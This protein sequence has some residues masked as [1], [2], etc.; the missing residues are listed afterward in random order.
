VA[1]SFRFQWQS[2]LRFSH[3]L[4]G[5]PEALAPL[6]SRILLSHSFCTASSLTQDARCADYCRRYG[7]PCID[8]IL[9]SDLTFTGRF[10][11]SSSSDTFAPNEF[12]CRNA[13]IAQESLHWSRIIGPR[14]SVT[15]SRRWA[16][17]LLALTFVGHCSH[18]SVCSE[19]PN[20]L[21][22]YSHKIAGALSRT[23]Q[24]LA[25]S[26]ELQPALPLD[27]RLTPHGGLSCS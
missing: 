18:G 25:G 22:I 17:G 6:G 23:P 14:R 15:S 8:R 1:Q 13:R 12:S 10:K 7:T 4:Y 5:C 26:S 3:P 16:L 19:G 24:E 9:T 21:W 20:A 11:R 27:Y 2:L